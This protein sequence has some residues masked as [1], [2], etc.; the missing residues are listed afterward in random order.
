MEDKDFKT[1]ILRAF[2]VFATL[3][4]VVLGFDKIKWVGGILLDSFSPF[5]I[6]VFFAILL[7][8]PVRFL[9]TKVF[10]FK[11]K[12]LQKLKRPLSILL[13]CLFVCAL[14]ALVCLIIIPQIMSTFGEMMIEIPDF[15][16]DVIQLAEE[17]IK[18]PEK[19]TDFVAELK[20]ASNSW[21]SLVQYFAQFITVENSTEAIDSTLSIVGDLFGTTI[22]LLISLIF[23]ISVLFEK[24]RIVNYFYKLTKTF[25]SP[26]R[27]EK[28]LHFVHLFH[29]NFEDFFF[30]QCLESF[31]IATIFTILTTILGFECSVI[32][33]IAMLFLALIPYVGNFVACGFG[34]ILTVAMEN[35]MRAV[36][37][38]V[39]FMIVQFLDTYLIYPRVVGVKVRMPAILIFMSAIIGATLFNIA[40]MFL[41]IPIVTTIYMM[42]KERMIKT[43]VEGPDGKIIE[44]DDDIK[45]SKGHNENIQQ[46]TK[47]QQPVNKHQQQNYNKNKKKR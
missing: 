4:V 10:K 18:I 25:M 9:E 14:I 17:N 19:M 22:N 20:E 43:G 26:Q 44:N 38:A 11:G 29:Q 46:E 15:I 8:I 7:N 13:S 12:F 6:G 2:I 21:E 27:R 39:L 36:W 41:M 1:K 3:V 35:P 42:I 40:G 33:G 5:L 31:V 45:K 23:G 37:F 47:P 28:C 32:V 34:V 30:G 16:K 24:E